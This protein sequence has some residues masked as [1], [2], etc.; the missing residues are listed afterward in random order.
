MDETS[1]QGFRRS[2]RNDN[3][4]FQNAAV[5]Y[6]RQKQAQD[7][8]EM[9]AAAATKAEQLDRVEE[10]RRFLREKGNDIYK[11]REAGLPMPPEL[12]TQ[13]VDTRHD[14]ERVGVRQTA[15]EAELHMMEAIEAKRAQAKQAVL[16]EQ[17]EA[18]AAM[19]RSK[20]EI[21]AAATVQDREVVSAPETTPVAEKPISTPVPQVRTEPGWML[22][23]K[24]VWQWL[25]G[26]TSQRK[27][28]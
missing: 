9:A 8:I 23:A 19:H 6:K 12:M 25:V 10:A 2:S 13:T 15:N 22:K 26:P 21:A 7:A 27:A 28:A 20:A 16:D 11:L 1:E 14:V 18:I 4:T 17:A 5:D 24:N 3:D